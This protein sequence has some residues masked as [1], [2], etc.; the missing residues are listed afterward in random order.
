MCF[1]SG[2]MSIGSWPTD[3]NMLEPIITAFLFFEGV[4]EQAALEE[5]CSKMLKYDNFRSLP[6]RRPWRL[7]PPSVSTRF[8]WH[9]IEVTPSDV[10]TRTK[11]ASSGEVLAEM[12]RVKDVPLRATTA[13]GRELPLWGIHVIENTGVEEGGVG[14]VIALRVHHTIGDGMSLVAVGRSV[15]ESATGGAVGLGG[16]GIGAALTASVKSA[17]RALHNFTAGQILRGIRDVI[18]LSS[19][20]PDTPLPFGHFEGPWSGGGHAAAHPSPSG[21]GGKGKRGAFS[22]RRRTILL[23]GLPLSLIKKVKV[24]AQRDH[25]VL[26][27][28]FAVLLAVTVADRLLKDASGAT[29]NDVVM[30]VVA[31]CIRRYSEANGDSTSL[32]GPGFKS[33]ALIP[34]ALPR[35]MEAEKDSALCNKW[36]VSNVPGPQ[37]PVKFAGHGLKSVHFVVSNIMPQVGV[38]SLDGVIAANFVVDPLSVPLSETLPDH[39]LAELEAL[40]EAAGVDC[41]AEI[42]ACK[43][44]AAALVGVMQAA[45]AVTP[46]AS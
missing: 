43:A 9:D 36:T 21:D 19:S 27:A 33:R 22:G 38:V 46:T 10:I 6:R 37:E 45:V 20:G 41:K 28:S 4:P 40:A 13:D 1:G 11:A 15:L 35:N 18:V 39:F 31:G 17:K 12:D 30:S 5:A 8:E 3:I 14:T 25:V 24:W 34:V 26:V 16:G 42:A 2:Y 32:Q 7:F 29:V 44:E 23:P